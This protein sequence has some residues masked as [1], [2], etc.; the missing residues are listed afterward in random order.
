MCVRR[1]ESGRVGCVLTVVAC[2]RFVPTALVLGGSCSA[3]K[4]KGE[5]RQAESN[6]LSEKR[7][8]CRAAVA[9]SRGS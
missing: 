2:A 5:S 1:R 6:T 3:G 4:A 8:P 9:I 7:D